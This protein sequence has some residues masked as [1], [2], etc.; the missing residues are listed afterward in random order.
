MA[1]AAGG[2]VPSGVGYGEGCPLFSRLGDMGE[3][4]E[5][6]QR[7]PGG[8]IS[9]PTPNSG[10]VSPCPPVIYAHANVVYDGVQ[11]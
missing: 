10:G 1:R 3:R 9:S 2:L 6:P 8:A 5:L 7:G 4:S 11:T